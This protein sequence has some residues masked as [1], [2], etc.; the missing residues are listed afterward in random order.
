MIKNNY[1]HFKKIKSYPKNIK[2]SFGNWAFQATS[3]SLFEMKH[4]NIIKTSFSKY[5]KT[6]HNLYF[7]INLNTIKT[8]KSNE[9]RM[10]AG[11]GKTFI[12]VSKIKKYMIV[13]ELRTQSTE[14]VFK[15]FKDISYKLPSKGI[16]IYQT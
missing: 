8:S 13:F 2:L 16:I 10:G 5:F 3:N 6:L 15:F 1:L 9:S 11:K 4:I 7:K 14:L 12:S